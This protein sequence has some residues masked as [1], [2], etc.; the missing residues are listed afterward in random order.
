MV[1]YSN[2][3]GEWQY[4]GNFVMNY[5]KFDAFA[6][7]CPGFL[8][9]QN[10]I[11]EYNVNESTVGT[12]EVQVAFMDEDEVFVKGLS[13][14]YLP[15]AWAHGII[16]HETNTVTFDSYIGEEENIGQYVFLKSFDAY[17]VGTPLMECTF[18]YDPE[19]QAMSMDSDKGLL[20]NPNNVFYYALET[21]LWP[22]IKPAVSG[23]ERI[24]DCG[25]SVAT[26]WY[27]FQGMKV[28]NPSADGMYIR[29]DI[30]KN[31]ARKVTK[32]N[33]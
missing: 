16:N 5:E 18:N 31:G 12:A 11:M 1:G 9:R 22:T 2:D 28:E 15:D 33:L 25:E 10:W 14:I 21:Y 6:M 27:N 23:V 26:E 20:I 29:V 8:S 19:T 3:K 30:M 7:T 32:C 17:V 24:E 13:Q 4:A